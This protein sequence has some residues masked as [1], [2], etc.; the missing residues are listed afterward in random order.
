VHLGSL[1]DAQ[2]SGLWVASDTTIY[3]STEEGIYSM[4]MTGGTPSPLVGYRDARF[5]DNSG[6]AVEAKRGDDPRP[7]VGNY[8]TTVTHN[9]FT[10]QRLATTAPAGTTWMS[11]GPTFCVGG[12]NGDSHALTL[13]QKL[14]GGDRVKLPTD[15]GAGVVETYGGTS[16]YLAN[17]DYILEPL[18]G[19]GAENPNLRSHA[20]SYSTFDASAGIIGWSIGNG[21]IDHYISLELAGAS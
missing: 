11:C 12:N 3:L 17:D 8:A 14:D 5:V 19:Q 1:S 18:S 10:G 21:K 2:S 6:W 16:F 4:P 13:L 7:G 9:V 20:K 15:I